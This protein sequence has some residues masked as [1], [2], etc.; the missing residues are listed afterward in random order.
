MRPRCFPN[1]RRVRAQAVRSEKEEAIDDIDDVYSDLAQHGDGCH[2]Y[3][4]TS[5]AVSI[6]V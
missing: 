3:C 1:P 6:V 4:T 2:R 5:F